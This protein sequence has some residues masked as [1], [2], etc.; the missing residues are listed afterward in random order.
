MTDDES[1]EFEEDIPIPV[2]PNDQKYWFF[3]TEGGTFF[4]EFYSLWM[5]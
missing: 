4:N 2:L 1:L 5:G 3:R